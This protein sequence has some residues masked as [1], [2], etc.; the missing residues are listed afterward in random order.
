MGQ[1][2]YDVVTKIS[3]EFVE[4]CIIQYCKKDNSDQEKQYTLFT[5]LRPYL[6][7]NHFVL[8][9]IV[10]EEI[11]DGSLKNPRIQETFLAPDYVYN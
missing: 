9:V 3:T 1:D 8:K 4:E 11:E 2:L 5:Q 6:V 7:P 10:L